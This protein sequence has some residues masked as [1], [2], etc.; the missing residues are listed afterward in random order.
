MP[1]PDAP[2]PMPE[3]SLEKSE[4]FCRSLELHMLEI[5]D[6]L[7]RKDAG[8]CL[9]EFEEGAFMKTKDLLNNIS[10]NS[11]YSKGSNLPKPPTSK[12]QTWHASSYR[13]PPSPPSS[14]PSVHAFSWEMGPP[15]PLAS[16]LGVLRHPSAE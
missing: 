7:V 10:D 2:E 4:E 12:L 15:P 3:S 8:K 13:C 6:M 11:S 14:H 5:M 16:S 1:M 9:S